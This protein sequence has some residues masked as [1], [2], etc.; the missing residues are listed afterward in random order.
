MNTPNPKK[1]LILLISGVPSSGKTTISYELLKKIEYFRIVQETD[2]IREII[3]GYNIYLSQDNANTFKDL[4][5]PTSHNELLSYER[6]K[7]QCILM[8]NSINEIINRQNR[9]CIPTIISGVHIIPEILYKTISGNNIKY[10]NLYFDCEQDLYSHL[11]TRNIDK[12]GKKCVPFL[13][14][15]N[16][17]LRD[18]FFY[19]QAKAPETFIS[20]NVG[21]LTISETLNII[22]KFLQ[23]NTDYDIFCK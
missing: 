4:K 3:R 11:K 15:M 8:R 22:L 5:E 6:A 13:F 7:S 1:N 10:I 2:I 17:E 14:K 21:K 18:N 20:I 9:K 19:M 12:Y 23:D 16:S